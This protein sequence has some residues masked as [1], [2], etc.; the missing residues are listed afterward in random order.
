MKKEP[1]KLPY[2]PV[3]GETRRRE[4]SIRGGLW[5]RLPGRAEDLRRL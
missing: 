4:E 5:F 3:I 1:W 2:W